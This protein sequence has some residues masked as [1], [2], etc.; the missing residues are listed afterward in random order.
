VP[1]PGGTGVLL[2][3]TTRGELAADGE[4]SSLSRRRS[5]PYAPPI[6]AASGPFSLNARFGPA[7]LEMYLSPGRVGPNAI[8]LFYMINAKTGTQFTATKQLTVT[9]ELRQRASAPLQLKAYISGPGHYTIPRGGPLARRHV[10]RSRSS[11][12][13]SLFDEYIKQIKVAIR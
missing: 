4:L 5:S 9:A 7:E 6:D 3:R 10:G 8:H 13:V 12:A 1:R 11:I 2:R